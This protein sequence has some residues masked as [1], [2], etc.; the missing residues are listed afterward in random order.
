MSMY[1]MQIFR[2]VRCEVNFQGRERLPLM[3]HAYET[4]W[5]TA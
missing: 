4:K 1:T 3:L 2:R 5:Q